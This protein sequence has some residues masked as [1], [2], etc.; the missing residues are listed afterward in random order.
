[1][2]KRLVDTDIVV[3]YLRGVERA[4]T[5]IDES[6]SDSEICI[7]IISKMELLAGCRNKRE[8]KTVED[9]IARFNT[10]YLD[11]ISTENAYSLFKKYRLS[12]GIGILDSLVAATAIHN[13]MPLLTKNIKHF[14]MIQKVTVL[15]PY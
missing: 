5:L 7:S 11:D 10:I 6:I 14:S 9:F 13:E 12:H 8:I 3:D 15:K 1:M 2:G 4:K